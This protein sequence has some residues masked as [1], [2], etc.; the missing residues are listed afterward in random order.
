MSKSI[1]YFFSI[2]SP[3]SY[4]GLDRLQQ[5]ADEHQ[6]SITPYLATV[7]EENGGIFSRNRPQVRRDYGW[8]D[9]RRWARLRGKPLLL[10]NRAALADPTPASLLVI[11]AFL[12]GQDWLGLTRAL[13]Q[14][15]WSE[16]RNIGDAA[17]SE[18]IANAAGFAGE[19][20]RARVKDED[21]QRKWADDRQYALSKGVFG[22]PSYLYEDELYW[23]QDNLT[24]LARHLQGDRP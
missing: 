10:E 16:G 18:T 6:A 4:I 23:G 19:A 20:L 15:F 3:W 9:L 2:G 14:A 21:V 5:L 11:A 17:V 13:Q 8:R 24:F 12:D 22:F 7:I 1:D